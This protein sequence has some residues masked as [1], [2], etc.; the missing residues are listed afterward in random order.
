MTKIDQR[1]SNEDE[2]KERQ[3]NDGIETA[4]H[5]LFLAVHLG[6]P[7]LIHIH[8]RGRTRA[9]TTAH[10]SRHSARSNDG[11]GTSTVRVRPHELMRALRLAGGRRSSRAGRGSRV[12]ER[13]TQ[14]RRG[15]SRSKRSRHSRNRTSHPIS[16]WSRRRGEDRSPVRILRRGRRREVRITR[17]GLRDVRISRLRSVIRALCIGRRR[18]CLSRPR[19]QRITPHRGSSVGKPTDARRSSGGGRTRRRPRVSSRIRSTSSTFD[20]RNAARS[21]GGGGVDGRLGRG[22]S[23]RGLRHRRGCRSRDVGN[24]RLRALLSREFRSAPP[25]RGVVRSDLDRMRSCREKS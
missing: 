2:G 14:S 25:N 5:H 6:I 8:H 4:F 3:P 20:S 12:R 16:P 11:S 17:S 18:W 19:R 10:N 1:R 21:G 9:R 22:S 24:D 7:F 23:T 13:R 15:S